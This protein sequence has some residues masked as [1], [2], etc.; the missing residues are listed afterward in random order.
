MSSKVE[1]PTW[2]YH[3]TKPSCIVHNESED[4]ELGP[5][6]SDSPNVFTELPTD[7][8]PPVPIAQPIS[9]NTTE[10]PKGTGKVLFKKAQPKSKESA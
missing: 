6:W 5:G 8:D 3:R 2:R 1:Y 4:V 7:T 10:I 9:T